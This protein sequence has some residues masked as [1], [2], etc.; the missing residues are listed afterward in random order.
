MEYKTD[1][2]MDESSQR[3][4][5]LFTETMIFEIGDNFDGK[6]RKDTFCWLSPNIQEETVTV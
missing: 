6:V 1:Y 5:S 3:S 4:A 2:F